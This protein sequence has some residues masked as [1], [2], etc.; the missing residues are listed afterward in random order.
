LSLV[1]EPAK[2][3]RIREWIKEPTPF[4]LVKVEEVIDKDLSENQLDLEQ[5]VSFKFAEKEFLSLVGLL[6][7][8]LDYQGFYLR[9]HTTL[10]QFI[11]K[12]LLLLMITPKM[13]QQINWQ[14]KEL[15]QGIFGE[16][17]ITKKLSYLC[18]ALV[19]MRQRISILIKNVAESQMNYG[20][21]MKDESYEDQEPREEPQSFQRIMT[22]E[23]KEDIR[24]FRKRLEG[25]KVPAQ[26]SARIEEEIDRYLTMDKYHAESSVIKTY[27]DYLT[28]LPWGVPTLDSLDI[29]KAKEILEES[30]YGMDDVKQRVLEFLAIG[31]L[32]GKV[33]GKILCFV[34]PPGVGKT[35]I[36][37]SVAKAV[38]RKFFRISLGGDQDTSTLKG[39]RRT[40][41]DI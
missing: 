20:Q 22:D 8:E 4:G 30:H 40:Y 26:V 13:R 10:N 12:A 11:N 5:Q 31:K 21:A 29:D 37:E 27:L 25:K 19:E 3:V 34:G 7:P 39:F 18:R 23:R 2:K 1:L 24:Q 38:N 9:Q 16:E 14:N 35:S 41:E 15:I 17:S 36:D 33:H 32:K 6:R 28:A